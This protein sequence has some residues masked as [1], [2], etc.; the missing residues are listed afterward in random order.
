MKL[1]KSFENVPKFNDPKEVISY[2]FMNGYELFE[3]LKKMITNLLNRKLLD[4]T[5]GPLQVNGMLDPMAFRF[6]VSLE[7]DKD[8]VKSANGILTALAAYAD[9][10]E[11]VIKVPPVTKDIPV[12]KAGEKPQWVNRNC[13]KYGDAGAFILNEDCISLG[14]SETILDCSPNNPGWTWEMIKKTIISCGIYYFTDLHSRLNHRASFVLTNKR[15]IN[16][17]MLLSDGSLHHSLVEY[18]FIRPFISYTITKTDTSWEVEG[19]T[20][21]N[22]S[23][24]VPC[25]DKW[26]MSQLTR[27]LAV[28]SDGPAP[29]SERLTSMTQKDFIMD[30]KLK[31]AQCTLRCLAANEEIDVALCTHTPKIIS[32]LEVNIVVVTLTNRALYFESFVQGYLRRLQKKLICIPL[33][34]IQDVYWSNFQGRR[35]T[36]SNSRYGFQGFPGCTV[37]IG[38]TNGSSMAIGAFFGSKYYGCAADKDLNAFVDTLLLKC[39]NKRHGNVLV[40]EGEGNV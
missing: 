25:S 19:N 33:D 7:E 38:L 34:I 5:L 35:P 14:K 17:S 32:I 15:L 9:S 27:Y 23:M 18:Y 3:K 40:L 39:R 4:P 21:D 26:F 28:I 30:P 10:I 20:T 2:F 36:M 22:G 24:Y 8:A 12:V 13:K 1:E 29:L 37:G 6:S 11:P 16:H 31:R